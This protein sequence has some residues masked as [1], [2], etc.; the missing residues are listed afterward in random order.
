MTSLPW[1]YHSCKLC[2]QS[3]TTGN[4]RPQLQ[5]LPIKGPFDRWGVDLCGPSPQTARGNTY[6][7][8]AIEHFTKHVEL[9]PLPSKESVNK[10]Q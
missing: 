5:P 9:V 3:N 6:V 2:D 1:L 7:L 8:V 4:V 10:S